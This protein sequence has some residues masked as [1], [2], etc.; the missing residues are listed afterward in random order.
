MPRVVA[1]VEYY[2]RRWGLLMLSIVVVGN[3]ADVDNF[4]RA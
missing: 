3:F 1:D 2:C 4:P